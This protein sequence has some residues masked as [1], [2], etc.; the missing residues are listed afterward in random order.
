MSKQNIFEF[1]DRN[2]ITVTG[3]RFTF[4]TNP[5][6]SRTAAIEISPVF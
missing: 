5:I 3:V 2:T 6:E 1:K 4:E